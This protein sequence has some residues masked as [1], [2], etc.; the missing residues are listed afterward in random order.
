MAEAIGGD[1]SDLS[2]REEI[3]KYHCTIHQKARCPKSLGFEDVMA[4]VVNDVNFIRKHALNHRQFM[5]F[6]EEM[7]N[8]YSDICYYTEAWWLSHVKVL[9]Y[10]FLC[11]HARFM[12]SKNRECIL[13]NPDF[14]LDVGILTDITG[15]LN[16]LN[17]EL[18]GKGKNIII[19]D[20]TPCQY[21]CYS[22]SIEVAIGK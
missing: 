14:V 7:E 12:Q 17:T 3:M 22:W 13:T 16:Q 2:D 1:G 18:Q 4:N 10:V 6:L 5:T 20:N 8:K 9:E 21:L 11:R 19:G 15:Y